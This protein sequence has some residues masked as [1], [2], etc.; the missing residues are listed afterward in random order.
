MK[1]LLIIFLFVLQS[2]NAMNNDDLSNVL[3]KVEDPSELI[4]IFTHFLDS[5]PFE[6]PDLEQSPSTDAPIAAL[7]ESC[8][9]R[10]KRIKKEEE[11]EVVKTGNVSDYRVKFGFL[12][13]PCRKPFIT[14]KEFDN[15]VSRIHKAD[16]PFAC[17]K[18]GEAYS[19]KSS[20]WLHEKREHGPRIYACT[21]CTEAYAVNGDLNQHMK[22]KHGKR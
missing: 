11:T 5:H 19:V 6:S 3:I 7:K 16:K 14:R 22:R 15:H 10:L 18:C 2:L 9:I 8:I 12:C 1:Y 13:T 4:H 17:D 20:C 21:Q